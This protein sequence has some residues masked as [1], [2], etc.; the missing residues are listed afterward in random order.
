MAKINWFNTLFLIFFPVASVVGLYWY[1]STETFNPWLILLFFA[2]Y[3]ATGLSITAGYHRLFAHKAYDAH[4]IMEW[5]YLIFGA[6]AFENSALRWCEDHRVHHRF[7]D[8]DKDPYNAKKG[9]W[10]SHIGWI[11]FDL[12]EK[13][14]SVFSRDLARNPRV[15]FQHK[16]YLPIAILASVVL[17][18]LIGYFMGTALGGFVFG[19]VIR[20]TVVHHFT[21]FINSLCHMW[22]WQP[23]SDADTSKDNPVLAFFTYGEG[24][25]NFHHQFHNDYRNGIKW[26]HFDPSK[27][28]IQFLANLRL[29]K[30]LK[31]APKLQIL[32]AKMQMQ[33]KRLDKRLEARE[34]LKLAFAQKVEAM[35]LSVTTSFKQFS[36]MQENYKRSYA[37]LKAQKTFEAKL[38]L[39]KMKTELKIARLEYKQ[40]YREWKLV[41]NNI[42]SQEALAC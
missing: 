26:Y 4:P 35:H 28:L 10:Y 34:N 19:F 9:F 20:V 29:A 5:I 3:F 41:L 27:W 15:A 39:Q 36:D 14:N 22:G 32:Q 38:Q 18:T 13:D 17:P 37:E 7:I 40:K 1:F 30:N 24:Y 8:K 16:Y 12:A 23:Y 42:A 11:L 33:K 31:R 2:F 6:A 21:F 25:H